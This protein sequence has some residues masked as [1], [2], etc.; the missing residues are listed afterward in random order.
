M[1]LETSMTRQ[2]DVTNLASGFSLSGE[3]M[4]DL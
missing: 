3:I 4:D 2:N 1:E